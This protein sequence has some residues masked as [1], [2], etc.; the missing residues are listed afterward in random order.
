[1]FDLLKPKSQVYSI[2]YEA[3]LTIISHKA[4]N[5][6][7]D[8]I[9]LEYTFMGRLVIVLS[10]HVTLFSYI[11]VFERQILDSIELKILFLHAYELK[12]VPGI[13]WKVRFLS[14]RNQ[15]NKKKR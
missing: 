15:K 7:G 10:I 1:M 14:K 11:L 3:A 4:H 6:E 5:G 2:I 8:T 12:I 13:K 9:K